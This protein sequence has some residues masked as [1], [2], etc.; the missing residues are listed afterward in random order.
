[1]ETVRVMADKHPAC[2]VVL[3][4]LPDSNPDDALSLMTRLSHRV[5]K[6][7]RTSSNSENHAFMSSGTPDAR[8]ALF[9]LVAAGLLPANLLHVGSPAERLLGPPE[10]REVRLAAP[11]VK[12]PEVEPQLKLLER[13][14]PYISTD[15]YPELKAA[16]EAI[17]IY[18]E[19]TVM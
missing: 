19:S 10:V 11:G 13:G 12:P 6:A 9:F 17:P 2:E 3:Q 14:L 1:H 4:D 15:R 18:I 7:M 8:A 5:R 16:L